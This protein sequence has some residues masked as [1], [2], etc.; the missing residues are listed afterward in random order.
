M[1]ACHRSSL[2]L[3]HGNSQP[4]VSTPSS[5]STQA[6]I[7]LL[8]G[9]NLSRE[10]VDFHIGPEFELGLREAKGYVS[11]PGY[12]G[13][14]AVLLLFINS[15]WFFHFHWGCRAERESTD[16]LVDSS[17]FKRAAEALYQTILPKGAFPFIYASS[18]SQ[19]PSRPRIAVLTCKRRCLRSNSS[20]MIQPDRIDVNVHP[21]KSEVRLSLRPRPNVT[22]LTLR[23]TLR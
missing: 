1:S 17:K 18:V 23:M 12:S 5:S 9:T 16:R 20:L 19:S 15:M 8:Y 22:S 6:N 3:Q 11:G 4:E 10:L 14:K 21:T 2:R 7:A 13:K